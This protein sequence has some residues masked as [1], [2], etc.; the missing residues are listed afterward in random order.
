MRAIRLDLPTIGGRPHA[1]AFHHRP[2][3]MIG[4]VEPRVSRD[5]AMGSITSDRSDLDRP[6]VRFRWL[7]RITWSVVGLLLVL[8]CVRW[9]WGVYADRQLQAEI[10]R[11]KAAGEPI[12]LED[13]QRAPIP[14][15][16]NAAIPLTEAG[17]I[18]ESLTGV[19]V[20]KIDDER[21]FEAHARIKALIRQARSRPGCDWGAR[22]QSPVIAA[23]W[24]YLF[25][26]WYL[27][28]HL[29]EG[30]R[31]EHRLGNDSAAVETIHDIRFIARMLRAATDIHGGWYLRLNGWA[32]LPIENIAPEIRIAD[33]EA[34]ASGDAGPVSRDR[35]EALIEDLLDERSAMDGSVAALLSSRL[36]LVDT[37]QSVAAGRLNVSVLYGGE[38]DGW[39]EAPALGER[40]IVFVLKPALVLDAVRVMRRTTA[41][42]EAVKEPWRPG[43][44]DWVGMR[45]T[46]TFVQRRITEPFSRNSDWTRS[47]R[48]HLSVQFHSVARS[49]MAATALAM[50]LYEVD[51]GRRPTKLAELVPDYLRKVPADPYAADGRSIAYQPEATAIAPPGERFYWPDRPKLKRPLPVLYSVGPDGRDD[52]GTGGTYIHRGERG[53]MVFRLNVYVPEPEPQASPRSRRRGQLRQARDDDDEVADD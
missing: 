38:Y 12:L 39:T 3:G 32:I 47:L 37:A 9:G 40:V 42:A 14:D 13:F 22:V 29:G 10:D 20:S 19:D 21:F 15:A 45:Q 25:T 35:V 1:R 51:H 16:D 50:R 43:P 28:L 53:D 41:V 46:G 7:K 44:E 49:R 48:R 18:A 34:P 30:A 4:I 31:R 27:L 6:L 23:D 26:Q 2:H 24:S 17:K 5:H 36:L 8:V 52:N 33:T 11:I